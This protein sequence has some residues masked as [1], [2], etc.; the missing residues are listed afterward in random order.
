MA[1][2]RETACTLR[3]KRATVHTMKNQR[4]RTEAPSVELPSNKQGY[5]K[6]G[7]SLPVLICPCAGSA[8]IKQEENTYAT[9]PRAS[10][11]GSHERLLACRQSSLAQTN[12]G[13]RDEAAYEEAEER[14][15]SDGVV[16]E[17]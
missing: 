8:E 9:I 14:C 17:S 4:G 3:F 1:L 7:G 5:I 16:R 15:H 6:R 2:K 11:L 12:H 13:E 10:S